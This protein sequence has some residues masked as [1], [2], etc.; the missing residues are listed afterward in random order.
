MGLFTW[1]IRSYSRTKSSGERGEWKRR[2]RRS[3]FSRESELE[4]EV[5]DRSRLGW[6][7]VGGGKRA[8]NPTQIFPCGLVQGRIAADEFADHLPGCNV[9]SAFR[10]GSHGQRHA[11]LRAETKPVGRR[12][13]A[14]S[15]PHGLSKHVNGYRLL[16]G[17]DLTTAAE[18]IQIV[19]RHAFPAAWRWENTL[20]RTTQAASMQ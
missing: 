17:P 11:T 18:T 2:S 20:S 15:D 14:R 12:F 9:Q 8:Y 7:F 19:Q 1:S 4:L 16:P 13:L 10:R 3:A 5:S 6:W